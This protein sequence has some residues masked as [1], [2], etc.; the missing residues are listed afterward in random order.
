MTSRCGRSTRRSSFAWS[1]G[2]GISCGRARPSWAC[3]L[4]AWQ[5]LRELDQYDL[6][7][8][9]REAIPIGPPWIERAIA[10]RGMPIVFDFDDAIF[11][12]NV[13]EANKAISFLKNTS[14]PAEIIGFSR[15]VVVG[16]EFLAAFARRFNAAVTVVPTAVDTN[17]FV[18]RP[19]RARP[20]RRGPGGGLDWQPDDLSLPR[21]PW[22]DYSRTWRSGIPSPSRSAAPASRCSSTACASRSAVVDVA[23]GRAVQHAATSAIYPLDDDDWARGKCGF[24]AI[25]FM[26]CGVPVVAAAVGVNREIISDGENGFLASSGPEWAAKLERLLTDP[27]LRERFSAAGRRT[28]EE[29][30]SLRVTAPRLSGRPV[31]R[32]S[33]GDEP[34]SAAADGRTMTT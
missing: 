28:I 18:P 9:Y 26:A 12:P 10:R 32:R 14:R 24:K 4:A 16:N 17:R 11:L 30:Y 20:P 31:R 7:L 13:S 15:H 33:A 21:K 5:V 25:Q 6:V 34:L 8:L 27:A 29:R 23:R 19:D 22:R 1:T 3:S 2:P